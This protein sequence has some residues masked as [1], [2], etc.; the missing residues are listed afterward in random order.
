VPKRRN[1]KM[2]V[3]ASSINF[4]EIISLGINPLKGG[5]PPKEKKHKAN[6]KE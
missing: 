6:I 5:R 1:K 4:V 2:K 3:F